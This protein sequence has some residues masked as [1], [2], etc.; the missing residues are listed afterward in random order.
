M[1][2]RDIRVGRVNSGGGDVVMGDSVIKAKSGA[3]VAR[4]ISNSTISTHGG[5]SS[6]AELGEMLREMRALVGTAG[7]DDDTRE[8]IETH[9][10]TAEKQA[11]K[12]EPKASILKTSLDSVAGL[13]KS[14]GA[15][16][17]GGKKLLPLAEK[18]AEWVGQHVPLP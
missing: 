17:D 13:L 2:K 18:A 6:L 16:A 7:L 8:A 15:I 5:K 11:S 4:T 1:G 12:P 10:T 9:L 14:A 3:V